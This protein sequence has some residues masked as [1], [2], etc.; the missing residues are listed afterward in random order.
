MTT[1][2]GRRDGLPD[3]VRQFRIGIAGCGGIGS[4][5]A[6]FL[7]E[8][9][10]Y[11]LRLVDFDRVEAGNLN[12]QFFTAAQ[13]GRLKTVQLRRNLLAV[14]PSAKR[15]LQAVKARLTAAN[16]PA[17][18]SSCDLV[19]E[20]LDDSG[21]K[22]R[23]IESLSTAFPLLPLVAASGIAGRECGGVRVVSL[24]PRL[25]VVGDGQSDADSEASWGYKVSLAASLMTEAVIA[26][27]ER[28]AAGPSPL[29]RERAVSGESE[30]F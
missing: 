11:R 2:F 12:R 29:P 8:A 9:G 23:L 18:F 13:I 19:V 25:T 14:A 26:A 10:F 16:A 5:V 28:L 20:A 6:R 17:V 3:R 15:S 21:L 30:P 22:R 1:D 7:V 24:T 4:N 27:L